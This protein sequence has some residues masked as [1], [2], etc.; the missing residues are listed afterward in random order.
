MSTGASQAS[1]APASSSAASTPG[2]SRGSRSSTFASSTT[3]APSGAA[4]GRPA[5]R[6]SPSTS[7]RTFASSS[8]SRP[9]APVPLPRST[10]GG[11]GPYDDT[12]E[13][14]TAAPVGV[15]ISRAT[16]PASTGAPRSRATTAGGG[17]GS[18][19]CAPRVVP[20]PRTTGLEV[21]PRQT[22]GV[23]TGCHADD[24]GDRVER[25]DLV[26]VDLLRRRA[27]DGGLG[28]RQAGEDVERRRP[29][30]LGELRL[31]QQVAHVRPRPGAG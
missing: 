31:L 10:I 18:G 12:T 16:G 6:G 26:E 1:C 21:R 23:E 27:V 28:S 4:A 22:E 3:Q 5:S 19:P 20:D 29:H 17:T 14:S 25:A 30:R 7:R 15:V 9:P 8:G 13:A 11:S 24:V 2:H